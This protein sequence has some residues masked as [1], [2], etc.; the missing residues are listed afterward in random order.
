MKTILL[1]IAALAILGCS[2]S[3]PVN[4]ATDA[5]CWDEMLIAYIQGIYPPVGSPGISHGTHRIPLGHTVITITFDKQPYNLRVTNLPDAQWPIHKWYMDDPTS[6]FLEVAALKT[7]GLV[8]VAVDW[9][10][11]GRILTYVSHKF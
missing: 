7:D 4:E 6:L 9:H 10:S 2:E 1:I 8:H 11:G 3:V 5:E